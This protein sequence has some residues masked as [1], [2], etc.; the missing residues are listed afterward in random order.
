MEKIKARVDKL[1]A[2]FS[3]GYNLGSPFERPIDGGVREVV[4]KPKGLR[5]KYKKD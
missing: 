5:L 2:D 4:R 1:R 3:K